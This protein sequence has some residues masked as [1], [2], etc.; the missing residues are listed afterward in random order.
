[1]KT[2]I[3]LKSH[4][5]K[6][7]IKGANSVKSHYARA[8]HSAVTLLFEICNFDQFENSAKIE[9]LQKS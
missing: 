3:G 4:Q 6:K 2:R 7:Q 8:N 5:K 1:M 9:I